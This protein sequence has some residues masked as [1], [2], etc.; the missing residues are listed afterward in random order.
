MNTQ[1]ASSMPPNHAPLLPA[2]LVES[3]RREAAVEPPVSLERRLMDRVAQRSRAP[4]RRPRAVWL[5]AAAA[6]GALAIG[7]STRFLPP[8]AETAAIAQATDAAPQTTDAT[9]QHIETLRTIDRAL[10]A[11]RDAAA[12]GEDVTAH[13]AALW[14]TRETLRQRVDGAGIDGASSDSDAAPIDPIAI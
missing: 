12:D 8:A 4:M 5:L 2:A 9:A 13:E 3:L 11:A 7:V 1:P 14:H 10:L 6:V